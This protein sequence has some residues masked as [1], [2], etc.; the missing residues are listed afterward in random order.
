M[1]LNTSTEQ[2]SG[3]VFA[4]QQIVDDYRAQ[5]ITTLPT[6]GTTALQLVVVG[7][8]TYAVQVAFCQDPVRCTSNMRQ[9]VTTV[10]LQGIKNYEVETVFAQLQ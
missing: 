9:L 3:A 8:R 7:T 2:K 6:S 10:Y 4:A 5:P 1:K